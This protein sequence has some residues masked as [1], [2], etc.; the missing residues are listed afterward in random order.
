MKQP[1]FNLI[2]LGDPASGKA[3]QS[4]ILARSFRMHSVDFGKYLREIQ[5]SRS[6][7]A[8]HR[9][10]R[11]AMLSTYNQGKVFPTEIA[12]QFFKRQ[13]E[14]APESKGILF[15]GNPKMLGE[16]KVICRTMEKNGRKRDSVL[17]LYLSVPAREILKRMR[18]RKELINGK[19]VKR[20]D[21][22]MLAARN[23]IRYFK[24][25]IPDVLNFLSSKYEFKKISG[26]GSRKQVHKRIIK[27]IN[28][29]IK[30]QKRNK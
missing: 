19:Y 2:F 13:I 23:R 7:D 8:L 10:I 27:R 29:F 9:K 16:A 21:D 3:T 20:S 28:G 6:T 18:K 12:K 17:V 25:R 22:D 4:A 5:H 30:R 24:K 14:S 1:R 11:K 26:L 15:D